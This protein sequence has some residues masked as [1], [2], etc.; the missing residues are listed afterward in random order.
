M[1]DKYEV[2]ASR[3]LDNEGGGLG[4][5]RVTGLNH[6]IILWPANSNYCDIIISSTSILGQSAIITL[7]TRHRIQYIHRI[8]TWMDN[9]SGHEYS[10]A[11]IPSEMT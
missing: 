10:R 6:V 5:G 11:L 9:H 1:I 3:T 8:T 7:I 4:D 2:C